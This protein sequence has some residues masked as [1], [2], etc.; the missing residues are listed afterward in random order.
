MR[1][2]DLM[3]FMTETDALQVSKAYEGSFPKAY[4]T[5][6]D[7]VFWVLCIKQYGRLLFLRDNGNFE[8]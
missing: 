4:R 5:V 3:T 7:I 6:N 8:R 1:T 2:N